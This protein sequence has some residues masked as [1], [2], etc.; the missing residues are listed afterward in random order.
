MF[1]FVASSRR[2]CTSIRRQVEEVEGT[3]NSRNEEFI[4][5]PI[6]SGITLENNAVE[7]TR[8]CQETLRAKWSELS[9]SKWK[10]SLPECGWKPLANGSW[11]TAWPPSRRGRDSIIICARK[12]NPLGRVNV[13]HGKHKGLFR[14]W[15]RHGLLCHH[16][17]RLLWI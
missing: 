11:G 3:I 15:H 12:E 7:R 8:E 1:N 2:S 5:T 14:A 13:G 16:Q 9:K 6:G 17:W 10:F 4:E